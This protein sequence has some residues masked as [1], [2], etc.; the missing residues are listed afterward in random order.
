MPPRPTSHPAGAHFPVDCAP[1]WMPLCASRSPL[2]IASGYSPAVFTCKQLFTTRGWTYDFRESGNAMQPPWWWKVFAIH[3]IFEQ[4]P[5][6]MDLLVMWMDTDAL[7]TDCHTNEPVSLATSDPAACMWISPDAPP[8]RSPFN[9]GCFLVRGSPAG[10]TLMRTWCS[11]YDPGVW[12]QVPQPIQPQE[13]ASVRFGIE[14]QPR[15][16]QTR[17][18]FTSGRWAG[19]AFEQGAFSQYILPHAER[20]GVQRL[21]YYVFNEAHCEFPHA[22]SIAVHMCGHLALLPCRL[23]QQH[24]VNR[25]LHWRPF[26]WDTVHHT[27]KKKWMCIVVVLV[28]VFLWCHSSRGSSPL[29]SSG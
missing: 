27:N 8:A 2:K 15:N 13:S 12:H 16:Q 5:D 20:H 4:D 24:C 7:V 3:D 22:K 11:L 21:P 19:Q 17:W 6:P 9:A 1:C 29:S 10:R 18:T 28:I 14:K 23:N 25:H 26:V